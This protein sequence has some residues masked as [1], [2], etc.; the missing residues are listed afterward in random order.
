MKFCYWDSCVFLGWL[1]KESDKIQ[2]CEAAIRQAESG[3]LTLVTSTL[4]LAEVL[5]LKGKDPIPQADREQV[6]DFFEKDYIA[7]YDVD[8]LIA[9]AAQDLVWDHDVHP[10]D[11]IHVATA[12]NLGNSIAIEQFDT[13][14][15]GLIALSES[16]G[17]PPLTIGRPN[18][19]Q[20]LF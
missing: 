11:A 7:L 1:R 13:F 18:L 19:P 14:D 8:R 16:V 15:G 6:R 3:K 5:R 4:S 9:E 20:R 2:E 12:L 10:K 17:N